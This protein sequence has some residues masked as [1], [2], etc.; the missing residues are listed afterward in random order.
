MS[1][2]DITQAMELFGQVHHG[3]LKDHEGTGLGLPLTK[4]L[5]E[6]QGGT[7]EI[8]SRLNEGTTVTVHL[9]KERVIN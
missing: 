3:D 8:N 6:A 7:L 1:A 5:V 9:P 2:E 4:H